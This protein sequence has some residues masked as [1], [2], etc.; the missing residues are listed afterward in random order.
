MSRRRREK[1]KK[2]KTRFEYYFHRVGKACRG[3]TPKT[4]PRPLVL[5]R[6]LAR[7]FVSSSRYNAALAPSEK[8]SVTND[9]TGYCYFMANLQVTGLPNWAKI[10]NTRPNSNEILGDRTRNNPTEIIMRFN[11]VTVRRRSNEF[12]N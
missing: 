11:V 7:V 10:P 1:K 3:S 12:A 4:Y 6:E 9:E 2:K 5:A 8:S